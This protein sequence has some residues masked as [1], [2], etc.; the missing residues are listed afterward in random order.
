MDTKS[1]IMIL[2][3]GPTSR[4]LPDCFLSSD[5]SLRFVNAI[6]LYQSLITNYYSL[7]IINFY[8]PG[9]WG[10]LQIKQLKAIKSVLK[11]PVIA[12]IPE[13]SLVRI[14]EVLNYGVDDIIIT[15]INN[16]VFMNKIKYNLI[17][18]TH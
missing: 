10:K 18:T 8:K 7:F 13:N 6:N 5:F 3:D 2:G 15:P 17:K 16:H 12:I 11:V 14:K 4:L 1:K 9:S